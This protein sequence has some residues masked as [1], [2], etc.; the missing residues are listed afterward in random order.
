MVMVMEHANLVLQPIVPLP[1]PVTSS[2][3]C[4]GPSEPP[5]YLH[6]IQPSFFLP[7]CIGVGGQCRH[8]LCCRRAPDCDGLRETEHAREHPDWEVGAGPNGYQELLQKQRDDSPVLPGGESTGGKGYLPPLPGKA[9]L[10]R[11]PWD[12]ASDLPV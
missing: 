3:C 11:G 1:G 4:E 5:L 2:A 10:Q 7:F 8:T 12:G 6:W 9:W